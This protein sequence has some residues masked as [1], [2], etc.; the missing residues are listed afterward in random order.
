VPISTIVSSSSWPSQPSHQHQDHAK[1]DDPAAATA[2]VAVVACGALGAN[3][4][5]VVNRTGIPVDVHC[6]P[7]LLHNRPERIAG[8]VERMARELRSQGLVVA[9]A[10]ADCGTYG[11]LDE[12]CDRLGMARLAGLHCYDVFAGADGVRRL[13]E[14]EPGTYLLTDFLIR[15]F[16]RSVI[17]EL[18]L[19]RHPELRSDYFAHYRRVVWVAQSPNPELAG[20]ARQIAELLG[21]PL[22]IVEVGTAR[23]EQALEQLVESARRPAGARSA[24]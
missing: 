13:F 2:R 12:V 14:E 23:F 3:L 22:V 9:V 16:R 15:S 10:Y 5:D 20:Q 18:G 7:S 6:L 8:E 1:P 11:A 24:R 19:D 21:L 17:A 4:R